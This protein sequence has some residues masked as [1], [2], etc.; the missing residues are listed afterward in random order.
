MRMAGENHVALWRLTGNFA[1]NRQAGMGERDDEVRPLAA[2]QLFDE[3]AQA[4][5]A[6]RIHSPEFRR[7]LTSAGPDIGHADD[8]YF[9]ALP[10]K[11][12]CGGEQA[13]AGRNVV[14]IVANDR[15]AQPAHGLF[16]AFGAVG[17]LPIAGSEN[18]DAEGP[19]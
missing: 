6:R 9:H 7:R 10:L 14:K 5:D 2:A 17:G 18:I 1:G 13:A 15:A 8:G 4:L 11:R 19:K 12:Y 16:E 3:L